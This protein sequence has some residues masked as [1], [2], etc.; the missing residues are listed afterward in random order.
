MQSQARRSQIALASCP[1]H[2]LLY[3]RPKL[4]WRERINVDICIILYPKFNIIEI[5]GFDEDHMI[6]SPR[7]YCSKDRLFECISTS[8]C[9]GQIDASRRDAELKRLP[10]KSQSET[11]DIVLQRL[12][13]DFIL[14]KLTVH[15]TLKEKVVQEVKDDIVIMCERCKRCVKCLK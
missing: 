2:I 15:K 11:S 5:I 4:F 10:R 6:E 3:H 7:L 14:N 1:T 13:V 9:E 8:E 12:A